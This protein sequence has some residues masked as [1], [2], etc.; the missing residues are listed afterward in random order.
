MVG[1]RITTRYDVGPDTP[2]DFRDNAS[3]HG[4]QFN[5]LSNN[6]D[7]I[8]RICS[9]LR[10]KILKFSNLIILM[11]V[12]LIASAVIWMIAERNQSVRP[13]Q[14]L[15]QTPSVP[16]TRPQ[17]TP[18]ATVSATQTSARPPGAAHQMPGATISALASPIS[19]ALP[20]GPYEGINDR[21]WPSIGKSESKIATLSGRRQLNF[22]ARCS[23]KTVIR[24]RGHCRHRLDGHVT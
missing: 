17:A 23:T 8:T 20:R 21:R 19:D 1:G 13:V 7:R 5:R 11:T 24:W 18:V 2:S 12:L 22:M 3:D 6:S 4:G 14:L 10:G 9:Y 15:T 16:P